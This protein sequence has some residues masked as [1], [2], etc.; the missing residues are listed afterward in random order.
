MINKHDASKPVTHVEFV[1]MLTV[2]IAKHY[3]TLLPSD[4]QMI[5]DLRKFER[6]FVNLGVTRTEYLRI[7]VAA[8]KRAGNRALAAD[9]YA[10]YLARVRAED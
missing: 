7:V 9:V 10:L 5:A 6:N 8:L 1:A 3:Q 4:S 2:S